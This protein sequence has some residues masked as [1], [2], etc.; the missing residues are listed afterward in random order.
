MLGRGR[1]IVRMNQTMPNVLRAI[2]PVTQDSTIAVESRPQA[3]ST[4]TPGYFDVPERA[5][6]APKQTSASNAPIA[7]VST[8]SPSTSKASPSK[9]KNV[10]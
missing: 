7:N 2:Q 9:V 10:T 8:P 5:Q 1:P 4:P 3:A 6:N